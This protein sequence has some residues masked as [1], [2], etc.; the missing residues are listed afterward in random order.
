MS[1]FVIGALPRSGTA[2][3]AMVLNLSPYVACSHEAP[4]PDEE[5]WGN[6]AT[7]LL[8][9]GSAGSHIP[10][11]AIPEDCVRVAIR[12]NTTDSFHSCKKLLPDYSLLD[13]ATVAALYEAYEST[14]DLVIPFEELF[15][16]KTMRNLFNWSGGGAKP[17]IGKIRLALEMN[18]Q[19]GEL[20]YNF[21]V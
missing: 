21:G 20:D 15:L 14:C 5:T 2:W 11:V 12:R 8:A 7:P 3:V 17:P 6:D 13:H 18:I 1:R 16:E 9:V 19:L 10:S 4:F